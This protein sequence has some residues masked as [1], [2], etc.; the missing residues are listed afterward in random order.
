MT[1]IIMQNTVSACI[2]IPDESV[3]P[4]GEQTSIG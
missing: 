3:A 1:L 4:I 2:G